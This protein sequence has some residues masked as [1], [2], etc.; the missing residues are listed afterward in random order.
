M[1]TGVSTVSGDCQLRARFMPTFYQPSRHLGQ[2]KPGPPDSPLP[3]QTGQIVLHGSLYSLHPSDSLMA[4]T[5]STT[6]TSTKS[7]TAIRAVWPHC[8]IRATAS[9]GECRHCL[10]VVP[11][12]RAREVAS[13]RFR[14][15]CSTGRIGGCQGST[16][17]ACPGRSGNCPLPCSVPKL[18]REA[19]GLAF[20]GSGDSSVLVDHASENSLPVDRSV[21]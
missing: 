9:G 12:G 10:A 21:D 15:R 20:S 7:S 5:T 3:L 18:P 4:M 14:C 11:H 17:G 19:C 2:R 1:L 8:S 6:K 13:V 16:L